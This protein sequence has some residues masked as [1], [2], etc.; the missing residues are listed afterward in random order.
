MQDEV[1]NS[2]VPVSAD[3]RLLA[4]LHADIMGGRIKP[5]A[6]L[7]EVAVAQDFNVS[8]T[9]ARMALS[10]LE[11]QG[12]LEKRQ[13]RG[14]TVRKL[15]YGEIENAYEVRGTLE[16]LGAGTMAKS[17]PSARTQALLSAAIADM[18]A[19]LDSGADMN[20][21]VERYQRANIAFHETIMRDCGNPYIKFAFDRM[22]SLPMAKLGSIVFRP[23]KSDTELLRLRFGNMQ[24]QVIFNAITMRDPQRA[25][26][27]MREHANQTP[28]YSAHHFAMLDSISTAD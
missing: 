7:S 17:G 6:K 27:A 12:L 18:D 1:P 28:A 13:G 3:K 11:V 14:Y 26:A 5:G 22:D 2:D 16:G 25:E 20:E 4:Q 9:P 19:A 21:I 23:E 15:D 8:R 10:A 24:H